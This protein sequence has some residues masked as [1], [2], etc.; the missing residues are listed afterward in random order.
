M[1]SNGDDDGG[2][3]R[4]AV[5]HRMHSSRSDEEKREEKSGAEKIRRE[6]RPTLTPCKKN[7]I[8]RFAR[9]TPPPGPRAQFMRGIRMRASVYPGPRDC[10]SIERGPP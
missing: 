10:N 9:R 2:G 5:A 3:G 1:R 7:E 6:A 8:D 4:G